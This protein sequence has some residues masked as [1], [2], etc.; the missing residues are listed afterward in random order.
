MTRN[1]WLALVFHT[2]FVT[3]TLAPLAIVCLVAFTP[4]GYLSVPTRSWSLR[5]FRAIGVSRKETII[6][7]ASLAI[8][9]SAVRW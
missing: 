8:A 1:G 2:L 9:S 5:W 7:W 4:E 3:F 6:P